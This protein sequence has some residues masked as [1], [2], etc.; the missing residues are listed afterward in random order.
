MEFTFGE[1]DMTSAVKIGSFDL[2]EMLERGAVLLV[3]TPSVYDPDYLRQRDAL[4]E[5]A[6][7]LADLGVELIEVLGEDVGACACGTM[8]P[9]SARA[10]R[11]RFSPQVEQFALVL[12]GR[13]GEIALRE[14]QPIEA[15]ALLETL[16]NFFVMPQEIHPEFAGQA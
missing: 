4:D 3:F 10:L 11:H 8:L 6:S 1:T 13:D 16:Q 12:V 2:N 9:S 7:D 14:H 5:H 15:Q